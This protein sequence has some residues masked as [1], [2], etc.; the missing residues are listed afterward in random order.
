MAIK[1]R[2]S[3]AKIQFELNLGFRFL[4]GGVAGT[5]FL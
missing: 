1:E 5:F 4:S 2:A 3:M